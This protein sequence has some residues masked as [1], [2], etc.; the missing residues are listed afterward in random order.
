MRS[1]TFTNLLIICLLSF[2]AC[3]S[4][5]ADCHET[6]PIKQGE[7]QFSAYL[8]NDLFSKR[9]GLGESDKWYTNG[10]KITLTF[11][12]NT[13]VLPTRVICSAVDTMAQM[14][15]MEHIENAKYGLAVGQLMFTPRDIATPVA[16][17]ND[18]FY[19]GWL[20]AGGVMQIKNED[21][22]KTAELDFGVTGP[23]SLAEDAQKLI[24]RIF[25]YTRP[26]GWGN[27]IKTEPGIQ[28]S[29]N[30]I[31]KLA[32]AS[33]IDVSR[34]WGVVAGT[35][36]D[37]A[38]GG[39]ILRLGILP[40][41]VPA[42]VIESPVISGDLDK[43]GLYFLARGEVEGVLHN[44]FIDGSLF[45]SDPFHSNI[46][47]EPVVGQMT[48]GIV[49]QHFFGWDDKFSFLLNRRTAEFSSPTLGKGPLFTFGTVNLEVA[50]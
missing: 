24:H 17:P 9:V 6:N 50:F 34:Y 49:V 15:Q 8:E 20:Y 31:S 47:R 30:S 1:R 28:F 18:R 40:D 13:D 42:S 41:N 44:T 25:H 32:G 26:A 37:N 46:E 19:G 27:Q 36:F 4:S 12:E 16:Q 43:P 14:L 29:Y 38:K 35:E 45:R 10:I 39:L 11:D 23:I 48:F 5:F 21:K 3:S 7:T 22:I 2:W 33:H